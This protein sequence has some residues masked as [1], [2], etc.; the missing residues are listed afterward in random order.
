MN[1]YI[2]DVETTGLKV[3]Y[4]EVTQ[5]SIIRCADRFQLNR[6]IRAEYP[7]RVDPRALEATGRK[8]ADILVGINRAEA[9][10]ACE[11][12]IKED[13]QTPE[14]RCFIGHNVSFDRRFVYE[15]W[16]S[17]LYENLPALP[18]SSFFNTH[19]FHN[20]KCDARDYL[21]FRVVSNIHSGT[22]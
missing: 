7:Q 6:F 18:S 20:F 19:D 16:S 8:R 21:Q 13:E 5:I 1:Y 3:A 2:I 22:F 17:L 11:S 12:F 14:H 10:E 4:H 15:L 9:V